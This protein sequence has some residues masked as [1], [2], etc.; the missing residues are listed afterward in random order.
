METKNKIINV[1]DTSRKRSSL[2]NPEDIRR[3]SEFKRKSIRFLD[4]I[5]EVE[6]KKV[7]IKVEIKEDKHID[8]FVKHRRE[9]LKN[10]YLMAKD[11]LKKK[12]DNHEDD[13]EDDELPEEVRKNTEHNM[14]IS[15]SDSDS[16]SEK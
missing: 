8:E 7:E 16:V 4:P 2:K 12:H 9:S 10:E 15:D 5:E 6:N 11:L 14:H 3:V 1:T 13:D